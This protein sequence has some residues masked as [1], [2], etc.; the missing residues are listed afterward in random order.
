MIGLLLALAF[1]ACCGLAV[2][3]AVL[4]SSAHQP[5]PDDIRSELHYADQQVAQDHR[6][7]RRA[8]N[9]AAGQSWRNLAG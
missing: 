1:V 7:A 3:I 9:D 5:S 2:C 4:A 8:M 6:Q